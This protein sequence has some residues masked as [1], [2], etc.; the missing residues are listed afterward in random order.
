MSKDQKLFDP[1]ENPVLREKIEA[2]ERTFV[3]IDYTKGNP[4]PSDAIEVDE[5]I[6]LHSDCP[7]TETLRAMVVSLSEIYARELLRRNPE[8]LTRG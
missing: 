5:F 1:M 7:P 3:P 2:C 8:C 4:F 6:A